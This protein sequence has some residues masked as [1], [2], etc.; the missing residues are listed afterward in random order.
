MQCSLKNQWCMSDFGWTNMLQVLLQSFS[1]TN[2]QIARHVFYVITSMSI[3]IIVSLLQKSI[4]NLIALNIF[5]FGFKL[6]LYKWSRMQVLLWLK[7]WD[8]CVFGSEIRTTSDEVLSSLRRHSSMAQ[9]HKLSSLSSTRKNKFPGWKAGNF[10]DSTFSDNQKV[11]T[12]GIQDK[13][14]KK[15]RLPSPPEHKV[16]TL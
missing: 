12:E 16:S 6:Y 5:F 8:S 15:S 4:R 3:W 9:H 10:R 1:V 11:T 14:S 7:Q 2:K 13:W